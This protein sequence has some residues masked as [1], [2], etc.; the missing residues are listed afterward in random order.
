LSPFGIGEGFVSL[1][2]DGR[3][4]AYFLLADPAEG[5][6]VVAFASHQSGANSV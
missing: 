6:Q 5:F 2:E 3:E 4:Q 1:A